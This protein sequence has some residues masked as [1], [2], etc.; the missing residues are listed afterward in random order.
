ML[1]EKWLQYFPNDIIT[2]HCQAGKNSPS[3]KSEKLPYYPRDLAHVLSKAQ[4]TEASSVQH[5]PCCWQA[6]E[7]WQDSSELVWLSTKKRC[8]IASVKHVCTFK[9]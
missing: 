4:L 2:P 1:R 9:S 5:S 7:H 6:I 3:K 8:K